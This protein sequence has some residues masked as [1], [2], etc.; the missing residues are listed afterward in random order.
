MPGIS[1]R[2]KNEKKKARGTWWKKAA[3]S[4]ILC[5]SMILQ[6]QSFLTVGPVT[7]RAEENDYQIVLTDDFESYEEGALPSDLYRSVDEGWSVVSD[8]S[9]GKAA[10]ASVNGAD[11]LKVIQADCEYMDRGIAFDFKYEGEFTRW[12]GFYIRLASREDGTNRYYSLCPGFGSAN[13][14]ADANIK[15]S[16]EEMKAGTW[17]RCESIIKDGQ[18]KIKVWERDQEEP[19][20][21]DLTYGYGELGGSAEDTYMEFMLDARSGDSNVSALVDNLEIGGWEEEAFVET[22]PEYTYFEDDYESYEPG[23]ADKDT[24]PAQYTVIDDGYSIVETDDGQVLQVTTDADTETAGTAQMILDCDLVDKQVTYDF[25]FDKDFTGHDGFYIKLHAQPNGSGSD[26]EYYYSLNPN[27]GSNNIIVSCNTQNLQKVSKTI[28]KDTWYTCKSQIYNGRIR[29]K[30]WPREDQEPENWDIDTALSGFELK[31]EGTRYKIQFVDRIGENG[32]VTGQIDN[33]SIKTW[34]PLDEKEEY[35]ITAKAN[36]EEAGTVSGGG[37]YLAG[38]QVTVSAVPNENYRFVNWTDETGAEVSTE[39]KYTFTVDAAHTLT[40]NFEETSLEI[41]SFMADGL[42]QQAEIDPEAK[43]VSLRFASDVDLSSVR[44]FFYYTPDFTP[45][46]KPYD[47]MDLRTPVSFDGWTITAEQNDLMKE[48]Y[49]DPEHGS[50]SNDGS[51]EDHA[52]ATIERAQQAVRE[53][54]EWTGDVIIHLAEGDYVLDETLKFTSEDGADKGYAVLYKGAGANESV[55]SSGIQL[56]GWTKSDDVPG[57]DNVYEI[58]VPEGVEYSRDLFVGNKKADLAAGTDLVGCFSDRN[59][60]GYTVTGAAEEMSTWRNQSDIE[61]VY[62]VGWTSNILPVKEIIDNNGTVEV[63]MKEEP[64]ENSR[65]KLNCNPNKPTAIQNAFELL[66]EENEWYFDREAGKIYYIPEDGK[67]PDDLVMILPT[68]DKLVEVK[69]EKES[70]VYG[71][72]FQDVGF[73][74][75]SF[76]RPHIEG[77]IELQASF[78][79]DPDMKETNNHDNFVKTPGGVTAAYAEGMRVDGCIFAAM[80]A[81]GFDYEEGVV[82][83]TVTGSRFEQLGAAGMQIGG[84]RVRDAQPYSEVTYEQ[85]V[86][87]ENAGADPLRVTEDIFIY[88]NVVDTVGVNFRGSIGIWVGYVRDC[89]L[90]NNTLRNISYSGISA[91]WGWG[92]WDKG[93]RQDFPNYYKFDTPAIQARFVIENNNISSCMQRL[94]DGGAIYTLSNTP[95]SII[96]GNYIHDIPNPYG[97]IYLDEGTG[98][99]VDISHNVVYNVYRPYFYHLVAHYSDYMRECE[100]AQ[101]DN[102]F[103]S[104]EPE[105]PDDPDFIAI[106]NNAGT[107]EEMTPPELTEPEKEPEEP[108]SKKTLEYF[109][110][111][112]K[113]YVEDGTVDGLVDSVKQLFEEAIAEGEAVMADED[114]TREE[115]TN[116]AFKLMKAIQAV[117]FKAADK[118]DLE[119]ALELAETIDLT[120]YVEEGQAEFLA[121]KEAAAGM[122]ADGDALQADVDAAWNAL[123]DAMSSLRLKADKSTLEDLINSVQD[124]DLSQYT[125]ESAQAFR[126]AL[127]KANAILADETLSEDDQAQVDEAAAMLQAAADGLEKVSSGNG[128]SGQTD[129]GSGAGTDNDG[130]SSSGADNSGN[131]SGSTGTN[132]SSNKNVAGKG[133]PKTGDSGNLLPWLTAILAAA[134]TGAAVMSRRKR[135]DR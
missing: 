54:T 50:D 37:R 43:T 69:G 17:Y 83:S 56:E 60:Y 96:R 55:I 134:G 127:A 87:N 107:V 65:I 41:Q 70:K 103:T 6:N 110:N 1:E 49:V 26:D 92:I 76:L 35:V 23:A 13:I 86:L 29:V 59:S 45:S 123:I 130:G 94:N 67:D 125:E 15:S 122:L 14:V 20:D 62:D 80:A 3:V 7:A 98:G 33:F 36:P 126:T 31:K 25:R 27:F 18:M 51:D 105:N 95:G 120:K 75:T 91:G 102:F 109:L 22:E 114:A 32:P 19:T 90:A 97:A 72:G 52:F 8:G 100:E 9:G 64:F 124:L 48:Y 39:K 57:V 71:L 113:G 135:K 53:I 118:T 47:K 24:M 84:V 79:F 40:A 46:V 104:G 108:V 99:F 81:G 38:N 61:F 115:V 133:T 5:T 116:A 12:D 119:M 42:T 128:D 129:D 132:G 82:G 111:K 106:E 93:G 44:P 21:W 73:K 112:A 58:E 131:N 74:Y 85:G 28:S 78:V 88:S 121:A 2:R 77:Q 101:H 63:H 68:L 89:T 66:D 4:G 16:Q 30:V 117:D 34:E 10:A 11:D